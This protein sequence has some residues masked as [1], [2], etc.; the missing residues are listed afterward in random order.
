[1]AEINII[2]DIGK[3]IELSEL[4]EKEENQDGKSRGK[5]DRKN[6]QDRK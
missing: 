3:G 1:M 5:N 6:E 2:E 4:K